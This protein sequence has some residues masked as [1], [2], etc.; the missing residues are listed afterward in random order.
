MLRHH[1]QPIK[2]NNNSNNID[3]YFMNKHNPRIFRKKISLT[4]L[5]SILIFN[6]SACSSKEKTEDK[7]G[8]KTDVNAENSLVIQAKELQTGSEKVGIDNLKAIELLKKASEKGNVE[9]MYLLSQSNNSND[10]YSYSEDKRRYMDYLYQASAGGNAAAYDDFLR[11]VNA[12]IQL[13]KVSK[14]NSQLE[15]LEP[16]F[17]RR[18]Q[19]EDGKAMFVIGKYG[20]SSANQFE[21]CQWVYKAFLLDKNNSEVSQILKNCDEEV[22]NQLNAPSKEELKQILIN[23]TVKKVNDLKTKA[24]TGDIRALLEIVDF[25]I[26]FL[27]ESFGEL[28][29]EKFLNESKQK[30]KDFYIKQGNQGFS[31]AYIYL[32]NHEDNLLKQ[33]QY[34][35]KAIPLNNVIA[36]RELGYFLLYPEKGQTKNVAKGLEYLETA[37]KMNDS[38]AMNYLAVWYDTN[39]NKEYNP[40]KAQ[41]LYEASAKLGNVDAMKNLAFSDERTDKYKWAVESFKSGDIDQRILTQAKK[42]YEKGID[43]EK[44]LS[45]VIYIKSVLSIMYASEK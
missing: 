2:L 15:K 3:E 11:E 4:F 18:A 32:A 29:N 37:V 45:Q 9:A 5:L 38:I 23:G 27:P 13:Y 36:Y 26:L 40:K 20:V 17:L 33:E 34:L 8:V 42:A 31:D 16:E 6:F 25:N 21:Q 43:V 24:S 39:T 35:K 1:F 30:I 12:E 44:D 22:L 28:L 7:I 41:S 19:K 14:F 10:L